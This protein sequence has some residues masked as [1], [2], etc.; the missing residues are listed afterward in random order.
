MR[1]KNEKQYILE[2]AQKVARRSRE[3]AAHVRLYNG[4]NVKIK[5]GEKLGWKPPLSVEYYME[6]AERMETLV[7][8]MQRY[9]YIRPEVY[10]Y[11]RKER[12]ERGQ[13]FG[14]PTEK[15]LAKQGQRKATR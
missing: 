8:C 1:W 14:H 7:E 5:A 2:H 9:G 15:V 10:E 6:K 4:E 12:K 13:P 3:L 11:V